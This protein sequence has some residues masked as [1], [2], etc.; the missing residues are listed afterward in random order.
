MLGCS[1]LFFGGLHPIVYLFAVF[2]LGGVSL[3]LLLERL[4][5]LEN[6]QGLLLFPVSP[7]RA[8]S[9]PH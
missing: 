6:L 4:I 8:L 1:P 2:T 3:G 9:N 7:A 5:Q